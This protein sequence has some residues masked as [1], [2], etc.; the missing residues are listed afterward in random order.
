MS[1][2]RRPTSPAHPH[3]MQAMVTTPPDY[4][5]KVS[6]KG[7]QSE[8]RLILHHERYNLHEVTAW[9]QSEREVVLGPSSGNG[10]R[11]DED[12]ARGSRQSGQ[13][14]IEIGD[15]QGKVYRS[16]T[17]M[18]GY[19]PP[20]H[21]NGALMRTRQHF[22]SLGRF[23]QMWYSI[24]LRAG[25]DEQMDIQLD[26]SNA[27][28]GKD[29]PFTSFEIKCDPA[30]RV[31][32]T[33]KWVA[34]ETRWQGDGVMPQRCHRSMRFTVCKQGVDPQPEFIYAG[35][36]F[37]LG[38]KL[39]ADIGTVNAAPQLAA[40]IADTQVDLF[41]P[42]GGLDSPADASYE[43]VTGGAQ[44]WPLYAVEWLVSGDP[45]WHAYLKREQERNICRDR[46]DLY[47][48]GQPLRAENHLDA[49]GMTAYR[50]W[51]RWETMPPNYRIPA[52]TVAVKADDPRRWSDYDMQH[53]IRDANEN[54]ALFMG[55]ND[56]LAKK[57][58]QRIRA[59]ARFSLSE[60]PGR[61]NRWTVPPQSSLGTSLGRAEA[62]SVWASWW[63]QRADPQPEFTNWFST[64]AE[65]LESAQQVSGLLHINPGSKEAQF[66]PFNG[67]YNLNSN[68][69]ECY[70][71]LAGHAVGVHPETINGHAFGM[72]D[73]S[74]VSPGSVGPWA[75]T[76]M[77][78]V[79]ST[80]RY[81]TR[82]DWP[83]E[84]KDALLSGEHHEYLDNY[85]IP[86]A[87]SVY[88]RSGS[89]LADELLMRYTGKPTVAEAVLYVR[90][91][92]T[93]NGKN[94]PSAQMGA[95][96]HQYWTL[97]GEWT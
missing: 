97:L 65:I 12:L 47:Q 84:I 25:L 14:W 92:L 93:R 33:Q 45:A 59:N 2:I 26:W 73:L 50:K 83:Q 8:S 44:M 76:A 16:L 35:S 95:E 21:R 5:G 13:V 19:R 52:S 6:I 38:F 70:L 7:C 60:L 68:L 48:D 74:W 96:I 36:D 23:G 55:A 18:D 17:G 57:Q 46:I 88:K 61:A 20:V 32:G 37:Y 66:P 91:W 11:I 89:P 87:L 22:V 42:V 71:L 10:V 82:A 34:S 94:A 72:R 41:W 24:T 40:M 30:L 29:A 3:V 69:E 77:G 49:N 28:L 43:G 63:I 15:A 86:S 90:S 80:L 56:W 4:D 31:Y 85:H 39:P 75:H 53:G 58:L 78:P 9:G 27:A 54:L 1:T 51:D 81:E 79:N 64:F 62:F 67:N